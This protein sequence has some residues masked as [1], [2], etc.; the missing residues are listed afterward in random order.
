MAAHLPI[1]L[2]SYEPTSDTADFKYEYV[3]GIEDLMTAN[4]DETRGVIILNN[5]RDCSFIH[6]HTE[7]ELGKVVSE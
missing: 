2:T 7:V 5:F 3:N 1:C 6:Q 4:V